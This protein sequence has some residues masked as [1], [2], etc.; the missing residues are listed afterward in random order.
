M[1]AIREA[2]WAGEP[3]PVVKA[4]PHPLFGR[5]PLTPP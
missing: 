3:P 1:Q 4:S 2:D 5:A